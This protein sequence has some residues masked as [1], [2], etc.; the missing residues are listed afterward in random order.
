MNE[1]SLV[2]AYFF[3]VLVEGGVDKIK[4]L[5]LKLIKIS[6]QKTHQSERLNVM[7]HSLESVCLI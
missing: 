1:F 3:W 7:E 2:L 6:E 4:L 5:L